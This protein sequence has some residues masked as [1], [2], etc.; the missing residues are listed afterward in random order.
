VE[1]VT[2]QCGCTRGRI[3]G[4]RAIE[5]SRLSCGNNVFAFCIAQ[6]LLPNDGG[7]VALYKRRGSV[8]GTGLQDVV[9]FATSAD[10][11]QKVMAS[12]KIAEKYP[13]LARS[14]LIE[15]AT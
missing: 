15:D 8:Q 14:F 6:G 2:L 3:T 12:S 1:Y 10:A 4:R 7:A 5:G 11:A 9:A 13:F